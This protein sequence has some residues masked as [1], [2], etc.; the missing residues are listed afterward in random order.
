MLAKLAIPFVCLGLLSA[1]AGGSM[2]AKFKE[3]QAKGETVAA[4]G[5]AEIVVYR[6]QLMSPAERQNLAAALDEE[7]GGLHKVSALDCD[8]NGEP[9][10]TLDPQE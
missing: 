5:L 6:C 1:C 7:L 4:K 10:F 8:A 2:V 3:Y 9:D